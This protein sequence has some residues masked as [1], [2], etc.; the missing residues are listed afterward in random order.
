MNGHGFARTGE[1]YPLLVLFDGDRNIFWIPKILDILESVIDQA[2]QAIT[3]GRDT[4]QGLR[5][6]TLAANDLARAISMLGDELTTHQKENHC[7]DFRVQVEGTPRDLAPILRDDVYRIAGEAVRNA[8]RHAQAR[9]IEVEIR[10]DQR[11]LRLRIRD[12]GKGID[13]KVLAAGARQG[14]YGLPG[15]HERAKLIGCKLAVSSKLDAGTEA[16]LTIPA[17]IAYA[18]APTPRSTSSRTG[19]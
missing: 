12:D 13:P 6:S 14:H 15:M 8:F 19:T 5:S 1:R 11:Q 16:E 3:E 17:S 2:R 9:R 4:V 10:Y 7:P 18:K